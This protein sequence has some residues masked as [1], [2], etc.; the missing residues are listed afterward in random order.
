VVVVVVVVVVAAAAA[1]AAAAAV[2]P[3]QYLP[4]TNLSHLRPSSSVRSQVKRQT[5]WTL[6]CLLFLL[7]ISSF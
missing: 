2:G 6:D 3:A 1:A 4:F 7:S 5:F